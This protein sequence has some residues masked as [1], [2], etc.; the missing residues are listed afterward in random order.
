MEAASSSGSNSQRRSIVSKRAL[1]VGIN[2]FIS[3]ISPLRGCVNDTVEMQYLLNTYFRYSDDEIR[4]LRDGEATTQGIRDGL[5]WLLSDYEGDGQ[6]VR[7]FHFSSHGTQVDDQSGD[8]EW[9]C[10]D[11]VIVPADHDW[12]KPFRDDDLGQIFDT[13]P[14]GVR[15]TFIADCCHSGTIQRDLLDRDIAFLPRY[16]TPPAEIVDRIAKL[17]E[18]R[19]AEADAWVA[20]ELIKLLQGIPPEQWAAEIQE[21]VAILLQRFRQN[22]YGSVSADRHVLLAACEDRQTAADAYID[23]NYRGAFTWA[24]GQAIRD[25]NGDLTYDRL[26]QRIGASLRE[27]GQTPQL[28]CPPE[29]RKQKVFSPLG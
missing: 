26:I 8:E 3:A 14:D 4:V 23:G 21:Y 27:Y 24:L 19:D 17:R 15:F 25:A 22:K 11:E 28:E 6:D 10:L 13:I 20:Q 2:Q 18:K 1:L 7:I 16:V 29:M 5:A 12:D 9:E